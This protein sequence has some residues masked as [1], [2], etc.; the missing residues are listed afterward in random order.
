MLVL[1]KSNHYQD[2]QKDPMLFKFCYL[3]R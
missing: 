3:T 2:V 1:N